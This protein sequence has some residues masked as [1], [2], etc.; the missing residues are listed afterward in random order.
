MEINSIATFF[1]F[2]YDNWGS[3]VAGSITGYHILEKN[4]GLRA[5]GRNILGQK[6]ATL[7][8]AAPAAPVAAPAT[9]AK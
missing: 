8:A 5:I 3:I 2:V 9:P 4:G 1:G 7:S 6:A